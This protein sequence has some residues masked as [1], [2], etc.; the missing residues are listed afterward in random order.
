MQTQNVLTDI[1]QEVNDLSNIL[2]EQ[3]ADNFEK[4]IS[5]D[6]G[7]EILRKTYRD[8]LI[9]LWDELPDIEN[10]KINYED[11]E[12][13]IQKLGEFLRELK[14]SIQYPH[15]KKVNNQF[16][17][18]QKVWGADNIPWLAFLENCTDEELDKLDGLSL[19]LN[20]F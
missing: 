18:W 2:N 12:T 9:G 7:K 4:V 6:E 1:D 3:M 17:D 11:L 8:D 5:T 20:H 10:E 15:R 13:F 14:K 19:E 16:V